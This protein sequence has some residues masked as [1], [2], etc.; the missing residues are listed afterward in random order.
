MLVGMLDVPASSSLAACPDESRVTCSQARINPCLG[1]RPARLAGPPLVTW[2]GP[3]GPVPCLVGDG[4]HDEKEPEKV[5][6]TA[7]RGVAA[8]VGGDREPNQVQLTSEWLRRGIHTATNVVAVMMLKGGAGKT[9][10][11][12]LIADALARFGASVLVID[13]DPQGNSCIGFGQPVRLVPQGTSRIGNRPV[14]VPHTN[15][16][17]EVIDSGEPGVLDEAITLVDWGYDRTCPFERGG[18]MFPSL[19]G[20]IGLVPVYDALDS[21]A[22][23]WTLADLERLGHALLLPAAEGDGISPNRRWDV[24]LIDTPHGA[25]LIQIQAVKAA[26]RALL[27]TPAE[28]F[29]TDAVSKTVRMVKE[30]RDQYHHTDLSV[31]GMVFNES[32]PRSR[33]QR[34]L[35][36][37]VEQARAEG[38]EEVSMPLW[39]CRIPRR[40]V[41]AESQLAEAPVSA[42]LA[43]SGTRAAAAAV[44]QH[45]EAAAIRLLEAI[46]HPRAR[47]IKQ[48][49]KDAWPEAERLPVVV[50]V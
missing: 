3:P 12:L 31:I 29:G 50:E 11:T 37:Q 14:M 33:T 28:K 8:A 25:H 5:N 24:V 27:V 30:I 49:W 20:T 9:S 35:T 42:F 21:L 32:V 19:T 13:M 16:V 44:C 7:A 4:G 26:H 47:E 36:A 22:A 43:V 1:T 18:P 6:T 38:I 46:G 45:A 41:I 40:G 23:T 17:I 39:P 48:A 2:L 34:N 10:L 15:T